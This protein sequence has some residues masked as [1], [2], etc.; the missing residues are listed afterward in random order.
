VI[1]R[2]AGLGKYHANANMG[3]LQHALSQQWHASALEVIRH[4][5]LF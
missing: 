4:H 3:W 5:Y 2:R 1:Y